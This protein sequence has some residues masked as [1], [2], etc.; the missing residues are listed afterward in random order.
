MKEFN[1]HTDQR[2][3]TWEENKCERAR[4]DAELQEILREQ[5]NN[6]KMR[7]KEEIENMRK[8]ATHKANPIKKFSEVIIVPS[9]K[10]LT[11]ACSPKFSDRFTK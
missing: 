10:A 8:N 7:E 11:K 2:K 9:T 5:D 6:K 3:H 4:K 1:L